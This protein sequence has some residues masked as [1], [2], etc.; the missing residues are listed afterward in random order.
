MCVCAVTCAMG[1]MVFVILCIIEY[2]DYIY[3]Y[4]YI[5]MYMCLSYISNPSLPTHMQKGGTYDRSPN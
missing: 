5:Y 3:I 4:I 2:I 1:V